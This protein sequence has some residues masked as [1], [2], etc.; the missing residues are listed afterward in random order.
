M[1]CPYSVGALVMDVIVAATCIFPRSGG[2]SYK[3][4]HQAYQ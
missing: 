1:T 3:L 4:V 2:H